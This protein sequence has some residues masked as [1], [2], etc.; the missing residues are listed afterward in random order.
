MNGWEVYD[1]AR[2]S[3]NPMQ[4]PG[5]QFYTSAAESV[6]NALYNIDA[7]SNGFKI[8][9]SWSGINTSGDTII[10]GAFADLPFKYATAGAS[11]NSANFIAW[12]F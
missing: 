6:A 3:F 8:R 12:E 4:L 5:D 9:T 10:Y 2:S 7:L 1:T 11:S